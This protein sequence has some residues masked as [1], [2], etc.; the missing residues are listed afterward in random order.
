MKNTIATN[1]QSVPEAL[2]KYLYDIM[3][4][5]NRDKCQFILSS[6]PLANGLVQNITAVSDNTN[7]SHTVFGFTP[8]DCE[9]NISRSESGFIFF[10]RRG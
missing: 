2:T 9:L 7:E 8:V 6:R 10:F 3:Q 5:R 4:R 1:I